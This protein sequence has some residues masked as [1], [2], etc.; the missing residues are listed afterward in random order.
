MYQ[1]SAPKTRARKLVSWTGTKLEHVLFVTYQKNVVSNCMS[2]AC[3]RFSGTNIWCQ[4]LL[5]HGHKS[6]TEKYNLHPSTLTSHIIIHLLYCQHQFFNWCFFTHIIYTS[7]HLWHHKWPGLV[8]CDITS[9]RVT[10]VLGRWCH[11]TWRVFLFHL[12]GQ[13]KTDRIC[14]S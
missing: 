3:G 13:N 11:C 5:C 10:I 8:T 14:E 9:D 7:G 2:D 6:P 1:K 12:W 4:F